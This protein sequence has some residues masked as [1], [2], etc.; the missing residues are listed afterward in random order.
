MVSHFIRYRLPGLIFLCAFVVLWTGNAHAWWNEEWASR[1]KITIDTTTSGADIHAGVDEVP[2]LVR[3]HAGNLDF[4]RIKEDGSDIRFVSADDKAMLKHHIEMLDITDEMALIWVRVPKI[5][6][7]SK[8]DFLWMYY[9]NK[10]APKA[11][12]PKG[13]YDKNYV[14]VFH[15]GETEGMPKDSTGYGNNASAFSGSLGMPAMVGK[16]VTLGGG[17]DKIVIQSNPSLDISGG[18]TFSAWIRANTAQADAYLLYREEGDKSITIGIDK[19]RLYCRLKSGKEDTLM[20]PATNSEITLGQWHHVAVSSQHQGKLVL[21]IDGKDIY[22]IDL[23]PTLPNLSGDIVIGNDSKGA[24][25]FTGDLDEV[26]ISNTARTKPWVQ[27]Q[28]SSQSPKPT[29]LSYGSAEAPKG[30]GMLE[31]FGYLVI[32][33]KNTT[34]SGWSIIGITLVILGF[35]LVLFID[36]TNT[37]RNIIKANDKFMP[38]IEEA[39]DYYGFEGDAGEYPSSPVYRIYK[40]GCRVLNDRMRTIQGKKVLTTKVMSM[41]KNELEK[42]ALR[43]GQKLN[44]G[45]IL[46]TI[47]ITG[48]PFLGLLGTVWGVMNTFAAMAQVG[49]ANIMAIAP[50]IASALACTL[51]GLILAIPALFG[52]NYL[53]TKIK[54]I[55]ADIYLFADEFVIN[56]EANYTEDAHKYDYIEEKRSAL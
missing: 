35:C 2:V 23:S 40:Q 26:T 49:E 54:D 41:L 19:T 36:K 38:L 42:G 51:T 25:S 21:Y 47:G 1:V 15:F 39:E 45:L 37:I 30:G 13:T 33:F 28:F 8:T 46:L 52:Y 10:K 43:E 27:A 4:S 53:T 20:T 50:G 9:D 56:V 17:A 11:E 34:I 55:M 48:G 16:G 29:L 18:F 14:A 22:S 32:V 44:S 24:H 7:A 6:A 5:T 12:D 31:V 3:L